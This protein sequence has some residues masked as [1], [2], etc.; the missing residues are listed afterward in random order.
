MS[1]ISRPLAK[2]I[3]RNNSDDDSHRSRSFPGGK[4]RAE[5]LGCALNA[6]R[7]MILDIIF[8]LECAHLRLAKWISHEDIRY[9]C[10]DL[11]YTESSF[12]RSN[13][14]MKRAYTSDLY[15]I[16][17]K[18]ARLLV[19]CIF[20]L[21]ARARHDYTNLIKVRRRLLA[22]FLTR[23]LR[24]YTVQYSLYTPEWCFLTIT[25]FISVNQ[26]V[27]W[28]G[29]ISRAPIYNLLWSLEREFIWSYLKSRIFELV[30]RIHPCVRDFPLFRKY[31]A[32]S[33]DSVR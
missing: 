5:N 9:E 18:T 22:I 33:S 4:N 2:P 15:T 24:L 32:W 7:L 27:D 13:F 12:I 16:F 29:F 17:L 19:E 8:L 20:Y 6:P 10:V 31:P 30:L 1:A 28:Y 11:Y 21:F 26:K 25:R 3:S 23:K 14:S